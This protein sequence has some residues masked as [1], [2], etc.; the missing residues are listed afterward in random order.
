MNASLALSGAVLWVGRSARTA[1]LR[2][3]DL[4]G[5]ALGPGFGFGGRHGAGASAAGITVDADRRLWVADRLGARVRCFSVFGRELG[6]LEAPADPELDRAGAVGRPVAIASAGIEEEQVLL[7][8]SGGERRHALQAFERSGRV[9]SWRPEGDPH[10]A[11]RGLAGIAVRGEQAWACEAGAARVQVF[12]RGEFHYLLRVAPG[13][14]GAA[15]PLAVA[16]LSDGRLL[17][18]CNGER[19][20]LVLVDASG[21][22]LRVLAEQGPGEGSLDEP[23][24][25]V[26]H[27]GE[28]D[29]ATRVAALDRSGDRVQVFSLEGRCFGAFVDPAGALG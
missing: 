12:R 11:F 19:T 15:T 22:L 25:V 28:R 24:A 6:G 13:R 23:C 1:R 21:R 27:E 3:F 29:R 2:P 20:G 8:A 10:G 14:R 16:P 18:A 7:V 5:R 9:R 17:V 26:V 4:D